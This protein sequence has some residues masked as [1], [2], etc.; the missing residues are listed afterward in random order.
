[1][2]R[3]EPFDLHSSRYDEWFEKNQCVYE[4]ELK[5]IRHFIPEGKKGVEIGIGSGR[6]AGPLGIGT[7][8]DPSGEM[9]KLA[10]LRGLEVYDGVA[11]ELPFPDGSYDLALMVTAICFLDDIEAAF[12][13]V[14]RILKDGGTFITA[15][16]DRE[17]ELGREYHGKKESS[18]FYGDA[19]FYSCREVIGMLRNAG[20]GDIE[21]VQTVFGSLGAI[22]SAQPF[23][24]DYGE[25]SFVVISS[26]CNKKKE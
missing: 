20:F 18:V 16:V 24:E 23:T 13:E 9:R 17:S 2:P 6:F 19:T 22:T 25:G 8:I 5:A 11:E 26:K 12:G 10:A 7:G 21:T 15:F 3:T 4:S 1:M 14:R